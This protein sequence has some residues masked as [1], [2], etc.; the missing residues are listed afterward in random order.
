[1]DPPL[2]AVVLVCGD[3]G[4][5]DGDDGGAVEHWVHRGVELD[6]VNHQTYW[7]VVGLE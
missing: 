6:I 5:D 4:D 7:W 3:D 2:V 1:M